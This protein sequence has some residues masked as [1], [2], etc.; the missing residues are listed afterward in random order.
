[1]GWPHEQN[2]TD[3]LSAYV[4]AGQKGLEG[5]EGSTG[6]ISGL[7]ATYVVKIR[8]IGTAHIHMDACMP[9]A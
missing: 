8:K 3:I 2:L 1:M 7:L 6:L 9:P 5:T 4:L